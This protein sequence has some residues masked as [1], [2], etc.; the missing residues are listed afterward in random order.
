MILGALRPRLS[1]VLRCM[2]ASEEMCPGL[3][4]SEEA[5]EEAQA[6]V[7]DGHDAEDVGHGFEAPPLAALQLEAGWLLG[8]GEGCLAAVERAAQCAVQVLGARLMLAAA[9]MERERA[10]EYVQWAQQSRKGCEKDLLGLRGGE[11]LEEG[12]RPV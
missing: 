10:K 7:L 1:A 4:S 8:L 11:L 9:D 5:L 2:R 12:D 3:W 6:E